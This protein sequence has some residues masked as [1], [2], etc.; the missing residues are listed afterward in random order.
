[1]QAPSLDFFCMSRCGQSPSSKSE[2]GCQMPDLSS[3]ARR[4]KE[5]ARY[6]MQ[7]FTTKAR[8]SPRKKGRFRLVSLVTWR[9]EP[10][11]SPQDSSPRSKTRDPVKTQSSSP[12]VPKPHPAVCH[13]TFVVC[14]SQVSSGCSMK[15]LKA[16]STRPSFQSPR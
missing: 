15:T 7:G 16:S 8:R 6:Q 5:D 13:L 11:P 1:M 14:T 4:T 10:I 9:F 2:G 12:P 3:I